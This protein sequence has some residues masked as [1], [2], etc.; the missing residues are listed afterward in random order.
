M[1][2]I[3]GITSLDIRAEIREGMHGY[4][5][6]V[7]M[8]DGSVRRHQAQSKFLLRTIIR[9]YY[10]ECQNLTEDIIGQLRGDI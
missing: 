2:G 10:P 5:L 1:S 6:E 8:K 9:K 4:V 3:S 7:R